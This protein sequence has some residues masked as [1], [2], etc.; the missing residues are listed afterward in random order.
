MDVFGKVT[1]ETLILK[2]EKTVKCPFYKN[3]EKI[4]EPNNYGVMYLLPA[5]EYTFSIT[6]S[7]RLCVW[8]VISKILSRLQAGFVKKRG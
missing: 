8:L 2:N 6:L 3:E 7:T 4:S 5:F 1:E